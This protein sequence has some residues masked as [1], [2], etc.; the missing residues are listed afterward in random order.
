MFIVAVVNLFANSLGDGLTSI[1]AKLN[2][3]PYAKTHP[4]KN[5]EVKAANIHVRC[6]LPVA[7]LDV[8]VRHRSR[9]C[10]VLKA[11]ITSL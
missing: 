2:G 11:S 7:K 8:S 6:A 3:T 9:S 10:C 1:Q 4:W 5:V